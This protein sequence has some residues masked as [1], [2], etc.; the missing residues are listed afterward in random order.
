MSPGFEFADFELASAE[1]LSIE[2]PEYR[3]L[4]HRLSRLAPVVSIKEARKYE[5]GTKK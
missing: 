2:Y 4:I 5:D 3:P 1:S